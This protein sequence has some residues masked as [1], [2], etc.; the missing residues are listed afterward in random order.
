M[1]YHLTHR[2]RSRGLG[3]IEKT[4]DL[5][6]LPAVPAAPPP[7]ETG[8]GWSKSWLAEVTGPIAQIFSATPKPPATPAT[9]PAKPGMSTT[10]KIAL[11]GGAVVLAA[12]I[13]RR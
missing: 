11:A 7:P 2:R 8:S 12:F 4:Y 10:T 5:P 6:N 13:A 3:D 9:V 1:S